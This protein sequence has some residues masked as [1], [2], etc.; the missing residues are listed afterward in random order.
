MKYLTGT[1]EFDDWKVYPAGHPIRLVKPNARQYGHTSSL[2]AAHYGVSSVYHI[3]SEGH[4]G[5]AGRAGK[6]VLLTGEPGVGKT[7][8][9][10]EVSLQA[11]NLGFLVASGRCY[12]PEE[13]VPYYPFREAIATLYNAA[14]GIIRAEVPRTW[15][16]LVQILPRDAGYPAPTSGSSGE[17]ST[18][19]F[20]P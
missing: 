11:R 5:G 19:F 18:G 8:L 13:T 7:R 6:L 4:R 3:V 10:Q 14:P 16:Y 1:H 17:S 9:A 12:E 20:T 2:C 15:P